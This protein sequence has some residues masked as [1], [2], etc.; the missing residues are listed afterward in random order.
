MPPHIDMQEQHAHSGVGLGDALTQR[1]QD[2]AVSD[3]RIMRQVVPDEPSSRLR[4]EP[5]GRD[6]IPRGVRPAHQSLDP[7]HAPAHRS[8]CGWSCSASAPAAMT[9]R[10][11]VARGVAFLDRLRA[12]CPKID[13][14]YLF[15]LTSGAPS[16]VAFILFLLP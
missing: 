15:R 3:A 6:D 14:T 9:A 10:S 2:A 4:D 11:S 8:A 1:M 7:A 13:T 5:I 12:L 16:V